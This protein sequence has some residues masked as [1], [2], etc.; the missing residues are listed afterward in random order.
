MHRTSHYVWHLFLWK[1]LAWL[2]RKILI[3]VWLDGAT[4]AMLM[5]QIKEYEQ[6]MLKKKKKVIQMP[7]FL[8]FGQPMTRWKFSFL[9][10]I[11]RGLKHSHFHLQNSSPLPVELLVRVLQGN[12][13]KFLNQFYFNYL[14]KTLN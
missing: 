10:A 7:K 3:F 13:F 4:H 11:Y 14:L 1:M 2:R 9:W 12:N 8:S 6:T 5:S